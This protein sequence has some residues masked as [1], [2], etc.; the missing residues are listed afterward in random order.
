MGIFTQE[1]K[2]QGKL[3]GLPPGIALWWHVRQGLGMFTQCKSTRGTPALRACFLPR[4]LS[5]HGPR[6]PQPF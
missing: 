6:A 4:K 2:F 3:G 1:G 5:V